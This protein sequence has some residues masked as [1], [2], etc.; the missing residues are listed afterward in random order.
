MPLLV[1]Q[2]Q[3]QLDLC[4][5]VPLCHCRLYKKRDSIRG[6]RRVY[7]AKLLS[8]FT[9]RFEPLEQEADGPAADDVAAADGTAATAGDGQPMG[10]AKSIDLGW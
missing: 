1:A 2:T 8:H 3:V 5:D 10:R 4:S 7:A 9:A 6:L